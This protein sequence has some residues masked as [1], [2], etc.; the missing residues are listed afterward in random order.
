MNVSESSFHLY[1]SLFL[2]VWRISP[3]HNHEQVDNSKTI[4]L[5]QELQPRLVGE[6][7]LTL[8]R[9]MSFS[10]FR[11]S[12]IL[13]PLPK[14]T[15]RQCSSPQAGTQDI[16]LAGTSLPSEAGYTTASGYFHRARDFV[17]TN[18]TFTE[19]NHITTVPNS[20]EEGM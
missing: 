9:I 20:T 16:L 4:Q 17:I 5:Q 10:Y 18:S 6:S 1:S 8:V 15:G 14:D 12:S 2:K 7:P 13:I 3:N 11:I 19:V